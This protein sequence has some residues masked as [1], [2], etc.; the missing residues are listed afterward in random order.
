MNATAY[1][2]SLLV[3]SIHRLM[4]L[5]IPFCFFFT[6]DT[7]NNPPPPIIPEIVIVNLQ[8]FSTPAIQYQQHC[9]IN[10]IVT[11]NQGAD[12]SVPSGALWK[13]IENKQLPIWEF[14]P[15]VDSNKGVLC[16]PNDSIDGH[17]QESGIRMANHSF[18]RWI[19]NR[20]G[21]CWTGNR[22]SPLMKRVSN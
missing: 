19:L 20:F 17:G 21:F 12:R 13:Q 15:P 2:M 14:N 3:S 10:T 11:H 22:S 5:I 18:R 9:T 6:C 1:A 8:W 4:G 7:R 16:C